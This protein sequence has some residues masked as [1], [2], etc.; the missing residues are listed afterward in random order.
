MCSAV[1]QVRIAGS[2][3]RGWLDASHE[4]G[5]WL[6]YVR[7][8]TNPHAV[9]MRHVLINGQVMT[10]LI[11]TETKQNLE[12]NALPPTNKPGVP[13][14]SITVYPICP[15]RPTDSP[16][17]HAIQYSLFSL[18]PAGKI[19]KNNKK[20]SGDI[21]TARAICSFIGKCIFKN[22]KRCVATS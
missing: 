10:E 9:N 18:S 12:H 14:L 22:A 20:N 21:W 2:R 6:K 5:N 7:S 4:A 8:T 15:I 13:K 17:M 3:V 19:K 1:Y 16:S 11:T